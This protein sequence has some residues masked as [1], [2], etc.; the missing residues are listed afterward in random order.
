MAKA[1]DKNGKT[2]LHYAAQYNRGEAAVLLIKNGADPDAKN[3]NGEAPLHYASFLGRVEVMTILIEKGA[4]INMADKV[5]N[6]FRVV[7]VIDS[8]MSAPA[9]FDNFLLSRFLPVSIRLFEVQ[10]NGLFFI[11]LQWKKLRCQLQR[12]MVMR[13]DGKGD[14][15]ISR[16]IQIHGTALVRLHV[17]PLARGH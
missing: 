15:L 17:P 8:K 12:A 6:V 2:P 4:D 10:A 16:H 13:V 1:K 11:R 9:K 7:P 3:V 14:D 5:G